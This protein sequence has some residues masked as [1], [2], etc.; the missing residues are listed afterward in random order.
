MDI[1]KQKRVTDNGNNY[2]KHCVNYAYKEKLEPDEA[3]I[4]TKGYGVCDTNAGYTYDQMYAVK[5]YYEKTGDN[6]V[7]HFIVSYD[8]N[9]DTAEKACEYTEKISDY[10]RDD[11][12]MITA[13]H[14]EEQN[15]SHFHCHIIMNT[16]NLNNGKLYHSGI[17]ELKNLAVHIHNITGNYCKTVI[18]K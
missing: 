11:F 17:T 16:V 7:M 8:N 14:Q 18:E 9:V 2:F 6:P 3:L 15:G 4:R 10:F 13:V 12:Q 1:L 5:K